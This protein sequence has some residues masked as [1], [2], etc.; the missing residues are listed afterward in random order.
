MSDVALD[1]NR[2]FITRLGWLGLLPLAMTLFYAWI[3]DPAIP[4]LLFL[5]FSAVLLSF[6]AGAQWGQVLFSPADDADLRPVLAISAMVSLTAWTALFLG[7]P[8]LSTAAL[9]GGYLLSYAVENRFLAAAQPTW[10]RQMRLY[11]TTG[12]VL[13]HG[14]MILRHFS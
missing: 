11:L 6:V 10:Y 9:M 4:T 2:S 8:L 5:A 13:L 12:V 3:K 1:K 14:F 7:V